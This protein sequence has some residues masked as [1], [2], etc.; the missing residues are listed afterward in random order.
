MLK[1]QHRQALLLDNYLVVDGLGVGRSLRDRKP[2][3]YTFG[4]V[5]TLLGIHEYPILISTRLKGF[6]NRLIFIADDYDRSINEAI[7]ITKY[8]LSVAFIEAS[9]LLFSFNMLFGDYCLLH[10]T[11]FEN[12]ISGRKI[13]HQKNLSSTEENQPGWTLLRMAVRHV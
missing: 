1:K 7:K 3:R 2:V 4:K 12:T 13:H 5:I 11:C 10:S 8:V 6:S 9:L